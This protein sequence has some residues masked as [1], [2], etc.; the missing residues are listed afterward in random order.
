M[1]SE[2]RRFSATMPTMRLPVAYAIHPRARCGPGIAAQPGS[3]MPSASASEF[4]ESAVPMV[5][6]C[7]T[8]GAEEATMSMKPG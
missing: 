8:E 4:M 3:D 2:G 6:Q 5:L 1:M 7:P